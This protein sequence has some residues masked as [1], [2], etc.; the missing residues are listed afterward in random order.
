MNI[1]ILLIFKKAVLL[2]FISLAF[3][4]ISHTQVVSAFLNHQLLD[5]HHA[6]VSARITQYDHQRY[7][8]VTNQTKFE[9][10]AAIQKQSFQQSNWK[11]I[12]STTPVNNEA[13]ALDYSITFKCTSGILQQ[14]SISVDIDIND[15]SAEN[16]VVMP[17]AVYNGNRYEW[18]KLRYSPKL[19]EVQDIGI[20]KPIILTDIPKLSES[21]G[22]S[23]IQERMGSMST[24]SLGFI[25]K[26][27]KKG[28]W[29]LAKQKNNC[30][31][32]G[33]GIEE[34]RN[35]KHAIIS[36]TSPIV[37]ELFVY[38]NCD[39]HVPSWDKPK[40]FKNGD[41]ITIVF[42]LYSF[43][44]PET[45]DIFNKFADIRK[46]FETDTS[47]PNS[48]SY[49][50]CIQLLEEKFNE[51]NWV[52]KYGYYSVGFRENFLQDW[53]IGWTGGMISTYPLLF[54]GN[55]Q[56]KKNVLRNFDWLFP[57]GISPSGFYYDAGRN[58]TEWITGDIR[59][60]QSKNWHL[61]RKSGDAV[62]YIVKQ[63]MLMEKQGI[64]VKQSWKDGNKRVCDAFVKLWN[65]YHQI[66]QFVDANTGDII[67]GGS[68]SGGIIP[69]A[70]TLA[71][72]YYHHP[73]Y[74]KT[75]KAIAIYYNENFTKKG[76][77]CGGPGDALQNFDSESSY[78]LV[79]SY[80][81]LYELSNE[82]KF[83]EMAENAAKQFATWVVSY[84]YQFIDTTSYAKAH[85]HTTGSVYANTQNKHTAPGICTASGL[86][87]LKLYR[88]TNNTFYL[89]LLHD[90]A[91]NITQYL[92]HVKKPLGNANAGWV[93][94]RINMTD[95]ESPENI[96][97]VLPLST[98][99]ETSLMLTTTEIPGLYVQPKNNFFIAFDNV[100]V[101]AISI[102]QN[103][104][105]LQIK[106]TTPVDATLTIMEDN[107][108]KNV[109]SENFMFDS[110]KILIPAG[111]TKE[112]IFKK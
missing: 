92:P 60:P 22:V 59:K 58:G 15:W 86:A 44:A 91:H 83:L 28:F 109:L 100:E 89:N 78:G 66:G 10:K 81:A 110:K 82:K 12:A 106:N 27:T 87:L 72:N 51:K 38:K 52:E 67:V 50:S 57:N 9:L 108:T 101:K 93:S 73:E 103:S 45:Q 68:S 36:I 90:I 62:W 74:L 84:N 1:Y 112:M 105:Q 56:T 88:F 11:I 65:R 17:A 39:A 99:A 49:S 102:T 43:D 2:T 3:L 61:I 33:I 25:S 97:Y 63:F 26:N 111:E 5:Q 16:Y 107:N 47:L 4:Q 29:L 96:G 64:T 35:R 19:Y 54:A 79:E 13:D 31:D 23:R 95:W 98:W 21:D 32:Y 20:D 48:L 104:L 7:N 71:S 37:R 69:A 80:T 34:S 94:E 53:Q 42:R 46:K 30:G 85:I 18:R 55:E 70:L 40:D 41:E 75:A 24:P 6:T 77:S 76:I 8:A 14:A